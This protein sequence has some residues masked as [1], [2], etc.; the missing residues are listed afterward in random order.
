MFLWSI[1]RNCA[2]CCP[3]AS[4][5]RLLDVNGGGDKVFAASIE[6]S[7]SVTI[8]GSG[9]TESSRQFFHTNSPAQVMI[10]SP[11]RLES[12]K[13]ADGP[14]HSLWHQSN[15]TWFAIGRL[16]PE[17]PFG[18]YLE[19]DFAGVFGAFHRAYLCRGLRATIFIRRIAVVDE[20]KTY[21]E[22]IQRV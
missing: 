18:W 2:E 8:N 3:C 5:A 15:M 21:I 22:D 10:L 19:Q 9:G 11:P 13:Q 12:P 17:V 4:L 14:Q 1:E 20:W 7:S 16:A 6:I